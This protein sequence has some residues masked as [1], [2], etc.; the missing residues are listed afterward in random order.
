MKIKINTVEF[1][2]HENTARAMCGEV[3]KREE[4]VERYEGPSLAVSLF[5]ALLKPNQRY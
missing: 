4:V 2:N 1:I 3:R 5:E